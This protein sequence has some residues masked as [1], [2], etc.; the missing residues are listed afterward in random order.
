MENMELTPRR[1]KLLAAIVREYSNTGEPVGSEDI[2]QRYKFNVS[3]ATIRNEMAA[4]EK[5]GFVE[6]PHTSAGRIP[7]DAGYRYFINELM[8]RFELTLREQQDLK[9]QIS[10]LQKQ[11]IELG[12]NIAKLL[13]KKTDQAAFALL[14][15]EISAT[16]L[17]NIFQQPN[18]QRSDIADVAEFFDNID[19]YA[20]RMLSKYLKEKPEALIGKESDLPTISNYS[21]IVSK[22]SLPE[23]KK[24]LIGIIG[25]KSMRYDKNMSLVEYIAKLVSSG[26]LML[27]LI[28]IK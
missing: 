24:G 27:I 15:E 21:L 1:A 12:R 2:N 14:P 10:E 18:M 9:Q 4:L 25:P 23:G 13:A 19:E 5:M 3:S 22:I 28:V 6:Q 8:K 20:D 26:S 16:G 7:T 17:S 11:H